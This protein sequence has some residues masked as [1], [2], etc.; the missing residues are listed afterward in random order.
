MDERVFLRQYATQ[1]WDL[2]TTAVVMK[3]VEPQCHRLAHMLAFA[4]G[5]V[6]D[7]NLGIELGSDSLHLCGCCVDARFADPGAHFTLSGICN[8]LALNM[9]MAE[10][11]VGKK[12]SVWKVGCLYGMML[13]R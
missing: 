9:D 13:S 8:K 2:L 12:H 10:A 5:C 11:L 3:D 6:L 7:E 1:W 4:I